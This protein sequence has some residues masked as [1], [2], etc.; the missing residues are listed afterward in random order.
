MGA[1][2]TA[3]VP[4]SSDEAG[5]FGQVVCGELT[6]NNRELLLNGSR[7]PIQIGV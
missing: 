3:G 7:G 2:V 1:K 5:L 4:D 6:L